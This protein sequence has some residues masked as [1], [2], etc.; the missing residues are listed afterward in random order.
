[1]SQNS[2]RDRPIEAYKRIIDG[3]VAD[4]PSLSARMVVDV[5]IFSRSVGAEALNELVRSLTSDQRLVLAMMLEHERKTAIFDVLAALTWWIDCRGLT[6]QY[7]NEPMP[8]Q[9]SGE[10]MHGDYIGRLDDWQWPP[11]T[12]AP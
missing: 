4:T 1:M 11:E 2:A 7:G 5:G 10:G 12:I 6:F 9:L 3:L 8:V